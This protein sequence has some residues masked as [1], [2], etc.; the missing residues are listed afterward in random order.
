MDKGPIL[1]VYFFLKYLILKK[2]FEIYLLVLLGNLLV[3]TLIN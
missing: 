2:R 1:F 3:I